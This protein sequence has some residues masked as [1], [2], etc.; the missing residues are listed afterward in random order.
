MNKELLE[1]SDAIK[2]QSEL[3]DKLTANLDTLDEAEEANEK[4]QKMQRQYNI[5]KKKEA[6]VPVLTNPQPLSNPEDSVE[7][8]F[9]NAA[10]RGFKNE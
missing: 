6:G 8:K 10:R 7:T 5:M 3:V 4:L 9:A 2:A 1:L